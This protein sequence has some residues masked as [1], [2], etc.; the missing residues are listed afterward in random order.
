MATPDHILRRQAVARRVVYLL[1]AV[2]VVVPF[3]HRIE[4][5]GEPS[6]W[7]R[8]LHERIDRLE[9]GSPVLFSFDYDPAS[10][11]EL[12]PMSLALL[13]H[14]FQR[15]LHPIVMTHWQTGV[16]LCKELLDTTAEE[17]DKKPGDDYVFLAFKP[18][19]SNLVL[20]M[21]E[22]LQGAFDK[23]YYGKP[24]EPMP[25][26]EGVRSL[27]DIPVV[28][29]L[30]A[31][32]TVEMWIAYGRDRFGF[33]LGAG[34]TA[35]IAPDLYPFLASGQ[36]IGFLGGLRGAADYERLINHEG[37]ATKGMPS[38]SLVHLLI[39]VLIIGANVRY[40]IGRFTR[41]SEE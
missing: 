39:I 38:Q 27:K 11:A 21:G 35:V 36:L 19:W 14:C 34:C 15:D 6:A 3:I 37:D 17:Y 5:P 9:P 22:S 2:A 7:A 25:A 29:D 16:G 33:D 23:D 13:R 8:K 40:L 10:M 26:L 12:Y 31:G 20:N 28:V 41:T 30:A 24:T 18:G 4:L 1:V 32:N